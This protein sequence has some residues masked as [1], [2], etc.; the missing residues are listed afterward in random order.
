M[1]FYFFSSSLNYSSSLTLLPDL[2]S[3]TLLQK[4]IKNNPKSLRF[5]VVSFGGQ[6]DNQPNTKIYIGAGWIKKKF[7]QLLLLYFLIVLQMSLFLI[8]L[9]V[10]L[11]GFHL[12]VYYVSTINKQICPCNPFCFF[13]RNEENCICNIK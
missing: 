13:T 9:I 6:P 10:N 1:P 12:F 5:R 7:F 4:Q 2:F 11:L 3:F 8:L